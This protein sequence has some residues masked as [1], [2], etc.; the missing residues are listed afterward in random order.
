MQF[1]LKAE[2]REGDGELRDRKVDEFWLLLFAYIPEVLDWIRLEWLFP[3]TLAAKY[4]D[5]IMK[6]PLNTETR[7][8]D[9]GLRDG[10]VVVFLL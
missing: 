9:S 8:T 10:K 7:E 5:K 4:S 3:T 1:P 2:T 6:F